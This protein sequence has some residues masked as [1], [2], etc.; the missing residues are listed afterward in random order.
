ML[1]THETVA[2]PLMGLRWQ[3]VCTCGWQSEVIRLVTDSVSASEARSAARR[4][5]TE[6]HQ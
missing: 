3:A 6:A 4:H 2:V 1:T 5:Q